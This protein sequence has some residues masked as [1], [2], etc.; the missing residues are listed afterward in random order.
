MQMCFNIVASKKIDVWLFYLMHEKQVFNR[1][2]KEKLA[3]HNEA[4]RNK[5]KNTVW[6]LKMENRK[7]SL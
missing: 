1:Y 6:M 7:Q 3:T 2:L 4:S 5:Y